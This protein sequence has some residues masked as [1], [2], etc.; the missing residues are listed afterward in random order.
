MTEYMGTNSDKEN[1][2]I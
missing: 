1:V 2:K